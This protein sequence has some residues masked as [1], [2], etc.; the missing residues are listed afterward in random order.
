MKVTLK[1]GM[2]I[3]AISFDS[4]THDNNC[5]GLKNV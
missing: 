3:T 1:R 2:L 5:C 4:T